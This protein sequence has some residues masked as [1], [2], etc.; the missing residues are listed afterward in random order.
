MN[1]F[2]AVFANRHA[3]LPVIHVAGQEQAIRNTQVAREAGCDGVFLVSH[4]RVT[5]E[6]LLA[7]HQ[8]VRTA[9]PGFWVGVNCLEMTV[10]A[11][12]R[13][14]GDTVAGVWVDD[15]RI[16]EAADDQPAARHILQ[17]Q[18]QTG[19]QG[20]YFGGVAF[21]YQRAV[22]DLARAASLAAPFV[23]VV[24]TSGPGTARAADPAKIRAMKAALGAHPL[25]IASGI[26]PE[27]V[28][29]YLA[30]ADCFLAATSVSY[31]FEDLDPGRLR[32]LVRVVRAWQ[33]R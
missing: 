19:W 4:G 15:A 23:D 17:V 10:E 7:I 14:V 33:P 25:A 26:S 2:R 29:D 28:G 31:T 13:R 20:L 24:T 5:D 11:V 22:R 16:D 27:N 8:A 18:Q 1:R 30:H 3:L 6:E 9:L 32:D 12:F 21:K